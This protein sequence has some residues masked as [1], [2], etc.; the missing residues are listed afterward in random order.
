M[1]Q[2]EFD[3]A[4]AAK[5][6]SISEE[7]TADA[8]DPIEAEEPEMETVADADVQEEDDGADD[9]E[10][11]PRD[12]QGRFLPKFN[13]PD[14]QEY[15]D[16]FD[17]DLGKA[18]RSAVEAQSLIGR[19]G[20]ELGDLRKAVE[21][22]S[23]RFDESR[24]AEQDMPT[25]YYGDLTE[26]I[27]ENPAQVAAHALQIGDGRLYEQAMRNWFDLDPFSAQ[28]FERAIE[29]ER[30]RTEF[31]QMLEPAVAPVKE[32]QSAR[33]FRL[34]QQAVVERHPDFPSV[35]ETATES[36]LEGFPDSLALQLQDGTAA[37]KAAALEAMYRWV[38]SSRIVG[39]ETA[40]SER[41]VKAK[42]EKKEAFVASA[43]STQT[44]REEN[45]VDRLK[46]FMLE[47]EPYSVRHGLS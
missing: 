31:Q 33:D 6:A 16:R 5:V 19:Q 29:M 34:A 23:S 7:T 28:R 43:T 14:V 4:L 10:E 42:A 46:K 18:L 15:L 26:D 17:G 47:P 2:D 37:E 30:I 20:S 41:A 44:A 9:T 40:R 3:A 25:Q 38:K 12:D 21:E 27:E 36:D 11:Q 1:N 24:E 45:G 8:P 22:L 32:Q 13:D 39:E 35:M